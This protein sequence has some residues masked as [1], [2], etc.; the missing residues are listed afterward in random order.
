MRSTWLETLIS[1]RDVLPLITHSMSFG[2]DVLIPDTSVA[3]PPPRRPRIQPRYLEV[4]RCQRTGSEWSE[5]TAPLHHKPQTLRL[6]PLRESDAS[7]LLLVSARPPRLRSD[8]S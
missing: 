4:R 3:I 6:L 5:W 7:C 8:E 1:H 2:I